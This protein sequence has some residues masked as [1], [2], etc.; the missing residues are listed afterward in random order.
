MRVAPGVTG[1]LHNTRF[2]PE[3]GGST[4]MDP[5]PLASK[6]RVL[7]LNYREVQCLTHR[8]PLDG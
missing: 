7:K 6:L 1:L 2:A 5:C 8:Q 3:C 4:L